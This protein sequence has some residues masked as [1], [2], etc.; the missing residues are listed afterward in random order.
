MP[1]AD[2]CIPVCR[3][4]VQRNFRRAMELAGFKITSQI[5]LDELSHVM[6]DTKAAFGPEHDRLL[7]RSSPDMR[8]AGV[9]VTGGTVNV[10]RD[11]DY[12]VVREEIYN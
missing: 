11:W 7:P 5:V 12:E 3:R 10:P 1:T 2:G 4:D 6:G 9:P 8:S